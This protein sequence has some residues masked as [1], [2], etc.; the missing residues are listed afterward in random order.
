MMSFEKHI[1]Q[2]MACKLSKLI[3]YNVNIFDVNGIIV[4]SSDKTR[5]GKYHEFAHK[6][7]KGE[8]NTTKVYEQTE[9]V[10]PG[11][12]LKIY[13]EDKVIGAVGITGD[14]DK[15][16]VFS[17]IIKLSLE[18]LIGQKLFETKDR[19]VRKFEKQ[20]VLDMIF[21][22]SS[23]DNIAKRLNILDF[24]ARK[25]F[26]IIKLL[27]DGD[28]TH[29][30]F[31]D[32]QMLKAEM[33]DGRIFIIS[34]DSEQSL[35]MLREAVKGKD[36]TVIVSRIISYDLLSY[37]YKTINYI[38]Q[39]VLRD[40]KRYYFTGDYSLEYFF[41]GIAKV[42]FTYLHMFNEAEKLMNKDVLIQTFLAYV[43]YNL[44]AKKTAEKM[45][46]HPNTL[47]YRLKRIEELTQCDLKNIDDIIKLKISILS[48]S[49]KK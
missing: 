43:K 34:D 44:C 40:D 6:L 47:K 11:V 10:K 1:L 19:Q 9:F 18:S 7:I 8:I 29:E 38:E 21:R 37:E 45:Y 31:A 16:E 27:S 24:K 13:C 41:N 22:L 5:I 23:E 14:P 12:N 15:T 42:R 4:G 30:L 49:N 39:N 32:C 28:N 2:N 46:V 20:L 36:C 25:H 26:M 48:L 3:N 35:G 33:D 17:Q